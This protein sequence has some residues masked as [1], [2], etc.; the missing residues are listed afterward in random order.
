[1][2]KIAEL[3]EAAEVI[4]KVFGIGFAR[5]HPELVV[6]WLQADAIKSIG[7]KLVDGLGGELVYAIRPHAEREEALRAAQQ[8]LEQARKSARHRQP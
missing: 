1:M 7:L 4:D 8:A 3:Q 6:G 2:G 5:G